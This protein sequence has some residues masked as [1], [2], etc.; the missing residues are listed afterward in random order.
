MTN[1]YLYRDIIIYFDCGFVFLVHSLRA[2]CLAVAAAA[3]VW[4]WPV[5]QNILVRCPDDTACCCFEQGLNLRG[6]LTHIASVD[7]TRDTAGG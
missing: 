7:P 4:D 5:I 6:N 2:R 1:K 3:V